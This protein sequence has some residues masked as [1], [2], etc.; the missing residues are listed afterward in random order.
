MSQLPSLL[1]VLPSHGFWIA[2][3]KEKGDSYCFA[4]VHHKKMT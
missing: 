4:N 1:A 2:I 3:L